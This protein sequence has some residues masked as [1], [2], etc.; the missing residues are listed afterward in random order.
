VFTFGGEFSTEGLT[1]NV[2]FVDN[3]RRRRMR[4][5]E[6]WEKKKKKPWM[7]Q[8]EL[9]TIQVCMLTVNAR[10]FWVGGRESG[11]VSVLGGS[12]MRPPQQ[13]D[14]LLLFGIKYQKAYI[15]S[16]NDFGGQHC[17]NVLNMQLTILIF[18]RPTSSCLR[19]NLTKCVTLRTKSFHLSPSSVR[20]LFM[21]CIKDMIF[22]NYF[23]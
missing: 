14:V 9:P 2:G 19:H 6:T 3:R 7:R 5:R 17:K 1:E 22:H 8:T 23:N 13:R 20:K 21:S 11:C 18:I 12:T 16:N 10:L 4:R 15:I